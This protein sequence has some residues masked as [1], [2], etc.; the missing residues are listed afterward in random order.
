[1]K[2]IIYV[3]IIITIIIAIN[4]NN[5]IYENYRNYN[6]YRKFNPNTLLKKQKKEYNL[7]YKKKYLLTKN[8]Y[9][10]FQ[11]IKP[12][13]KKYNLNVS[14]KVRLAD[15]IEPDSNIKKEWYAGFNK[16]KSKHIDFVLTN[17]NMK[18]IMLIELEDSSHEKE[19]RI[20]RDKFVKS[21][22]ENAGYKIISVYN[23]NEAVNLIESALNKKEESHS[24][25]GMAKWKQN[26][27][28]VQ[29]RGFQFQK[30]TQFRELKKIEI[31]S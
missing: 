30:R 1:M 17:E 14:C 12:I 24:P 2:Y 27:N 20:E 3:L 28:L 19:E 26:T 23:N 25:A 15:L 21:A 6:N 29:L 11:K 10:F 18:V 16:I 22:L 4:I 8:E 5:K 13:V 7:Q 9:S 31:K